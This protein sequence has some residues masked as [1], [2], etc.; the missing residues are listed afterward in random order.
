VQQVRAAGLQAR[1]W[2]IDDAE[3]MK[4]AIAISEP[5]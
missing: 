4:W 5:Q 1:V 2:N 3:R